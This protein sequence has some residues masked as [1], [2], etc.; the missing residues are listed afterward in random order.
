MQCRMQDAKCEE[1]RGF[2]KGRKKGRAGPRTGSTECRYRYRY[3][4]HSGL[5][6]PGGILGC[7]P[8]WHRSAPALAGASQ[9]QAK[10]GLV[11]A[12]SAT[13]VYDPVRVQGRPVQAGTSA[14]QF[15]SSRTSLEPMEWQQHLHARALA[16]HQRLSCFPSVFGHDAPCNTCLCSHLYRNRNGCRKYWGTEYSQRK[17]CKVPCTPWL[18]C[19]F[20]SKPPRRAVKMAL[21]RPELLFACGFC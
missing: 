6:R 2:R 18:A 4:H 10:K 11:I 5:L 8:V 14:M 13:C 3:G 12:G 20:G 7:Q 1:S 15:V 9:R 19:K 21:T 17:T 16:L